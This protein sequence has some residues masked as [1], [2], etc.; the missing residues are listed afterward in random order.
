[1]FAQRNGREIGQQYRF[2]LLKSQGRGTADSG[3]GM[4]IKST[5]GS[6]TRLGYELSTVYAAYRSLTVPSVIIP[7]VMSLTEERDQHFFGC[8]VD[9]SSYIRPQP[10]L[11]PC[12]LCLDTTD[13]EVLLIGRYRASYFTPFGFTNLPD[14]SCQ[15]RLEDIALN[16][17][18]EHLLVVWS[19]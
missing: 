14:A 11:R 5:K 13:K 12:K 4:E 16:V 8:V 19:A 17:G 18:N 6:A 7:A 3:C 15:M 2:P 10:S 9:L 1:M